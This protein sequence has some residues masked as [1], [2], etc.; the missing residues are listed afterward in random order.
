[1]F[2]RLRRFLAF[3]AMTTAITPKIAPRPHIQEKMIPV[4]PQ[5]MAA[6]AVLSVGPVAGVVTAGAAV[7]GCATGWGCGAGVTGIGAA[8]LGVD[9]EA[10]SGVDS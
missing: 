6:M 8:A 9:A 10:G 4:I 3:N 1:M 7:V 5:I 2:G